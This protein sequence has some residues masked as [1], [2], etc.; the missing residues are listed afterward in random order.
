MQGVKL[1]FFMC[2]VGFVSFATFPLPIQLWSLPIN[3][4]STGGPS[5]VR[6]ITS[7]LA[8][9]SAGRYLV[10]DQRLCSQHPFPAALIDILVA[11]LSLI[12]LPPNAFHEATRPQDIV[13]TGDS[14][15]ANICLAFLLLLQYLKE[16]IESIMNFHEHAVEV[17]YPAGIAMLGAHGD[18]T[19][20]L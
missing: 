18:A 15:G 9:L 16:E 4:I 6:P 2:M 8:R 3:E 19:N 12:Y 20:S 1:R 13:L 14:S 7:T 11:Y 5:S 17:H 10:L